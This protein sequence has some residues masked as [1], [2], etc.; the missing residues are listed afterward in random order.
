[1]NGLDYLI[2][3]MFVA[4]IGVGFFNGV[5][6]LTSAL[7][8]IYFGAVF[9]AGFYRATAAA[10]VDLLST[11]SLRTSELVCFLMLFLA[12]STLFA[13]VFSR[14]L[15]G[16]KLPRRF[17]ILDNVGGAA[18]GLLV[19]GVAMTLASLVL[20]VTL[21]ALNQTATIAGHDPALALLREEIRDSTLVPFFLRMSP[22][23]VQVIAPWFPGGLPPI[24]NL[25]Q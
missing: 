6:K 20:A 11:I 18:L 9:A 2:V 17:A 19:S 4:I 16:L 5:T 8:G 14:W 3:I 23:F 24:L 1:M 25:V 12:F 15:G 7:I 21:Q 10:L 13:I 22:F